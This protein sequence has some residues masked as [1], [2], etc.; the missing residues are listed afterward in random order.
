MRG[1]SV[2]N[3]TAAGGWLPPS[4][5][6]VFRYQLSIRASSVKLGASTSSEGGGLRGSSF[7][8]GQ[9]EPWTKSNRTRQSL[10]R[11]GGAHGRLPGSQGPGGL[12]NAARG[13]SFSMRP[14]AAARLWVDGVARLNGER[15]A[16][17]DVLLG[18]R[19]GHGRSSAPPC[20]AAGC[21]RV[22]LGGAEPGGRLRGWRSAW[23]SRG[24]TWLPFRCM[25]TKAQWRPV[26]NCEFSEQQRIRTR[27]NKAR[28]RKGQS[29][30]LERA[31]EA[32][33]HP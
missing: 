2:R 26:G 8:C 33:R 31:R 18:R 15:G 19:N 28:R 22:S 25:E 24:S 16:N 10:V 29:E 27:P 11:G 14:A 6:G 21:S 9:G 13:S 5:R 4:L 23:L 1:K 17:S 7:R 32:G 12:Q 3:G 30:N 20:G